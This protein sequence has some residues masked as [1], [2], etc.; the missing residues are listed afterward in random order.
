LNI[1][2]SSTYES[3]FV[4]YQQKSTSIMKEDLAWS[5]LSFLKISC[6]TPQ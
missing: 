5:N 6:N 1:G 2:E 4:L 3:P